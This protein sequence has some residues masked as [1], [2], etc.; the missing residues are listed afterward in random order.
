MDLD[1]TLITHEQ[2]SFAGN[3]DW[4]DHYFI[5]W[6]KIQACPNIGDH[7]RCNFSSVVVLEI[8]RRRARYNV[9]YFIV[10]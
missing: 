4:G 2:D 6:H 3:E 5:S 8:L 9:V 7:K 10:Q 1:N